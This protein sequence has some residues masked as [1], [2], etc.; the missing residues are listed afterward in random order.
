MTVLDGSLDLSSQPTP[1][2]RQQ[3][4]DR[5]NSP[6]SDDGLDELVNSSF[7]MIG[8]PREKPRTLTRKRDA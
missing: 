6:S 5:D 7:G 3:G 1:A 2:Q 4:H 8:R